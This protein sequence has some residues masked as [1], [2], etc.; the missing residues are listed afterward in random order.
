L[1]LVNG[2]RLGVGGEA[3]DINS[4]PAPL[5][6]RV[7]VLTG[8]AST[9]YGSDA[10]AGVVNFIMDTDFTGVRGGVQ[11]S[12]YQHDNNNLR[13]QEL[14][15]AAGYD[16]P[17]GVTWDGDALNVYVALGG[18]F[19]DGRGHASA[20][21]DY[22][23]IEDLTKADRDYLNCALSDGDDG[24]YCGGSTSSPRGTF[25]AFN[26]DWTFNGYYT[27]DWVEDGG[28]GHSFRMWDE[29]YYNYGPYNYIQRPDEK[30]NAGAF[31]HYTIND[32]F[33]PYAEIMFMDDYSDAQIAP[34]ANF[35]VTDRINCDNPM[36]S[37]QQRDVICTQAGY[38]PDDYAT[39]Y[40]RRRNSE[41]GP[42]TGTMGNFNYR[43][44]GGLR[45]DIN[46]FWSYDLYGLHAE[47][48]FQGS[49]L[50]DL[51]VQRLANALDVIEDPETGEW[52]CRSGSEDG[53][54]PWNIFQEGA[55]TQEA[56]DYI[57]TVA[58]AS[59]T[60]RTRV[61]NLTFKGDLEGHGLKI[62]SAIEGLQVAIG[63]EYRSELL[64]EVYDEVFLTGA[65]GFMGSAEAIDA[66]YGVKEFFVEALVPI[67][68]NTRGSRDLSLE[69]GYRYSD[70]NTSGGFNTYKGLLNWA[71]TDSW[72]LRGG[73]NRAVRAP[74]I[75]ELFRPQNASIG[76]GDICENDLETGV[77]EGT[78]EQCLRT[79][80][81]E[82]Q[83]GNI[84]AA[85]LGY[86]NTLWGGNPALEPEVADTITAG[87]VWT[88]RSIPGLSVTA[89]YYDIEVTE[90]IDWRWSEFIIHFC[91][92]TGGPGLCSRIHRDEVGSLWLSRDAYVDETYMNIGLYRTKGIDL[93]VDYLI[94]LGN[95]GYLTTDLIGTYLLSQRQAD[96][97]YDY[98]CVGYFAGLC[99]QFNQVWRHRLRAT[100]EAKFNL[101]L[102][103]TWRRVG[104]AENAAASPDPDLGD[105][106]ELERARIN[107][108]EAVRA[109]DWFDFAASYT[110]R[111]GIQ[112]T[113][114][115]NNILDQEPPFMPGLQDV[116]GTWF[117]L[118]GNY[119]PLGRHIFA[120][121][122]FNF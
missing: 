80:V 35:G 113:L 25:V 76:G 14:N 52:V 51:S 43:L 79:G 31:V 53:C 6:K 47:I 119:D 55:V 93:N 77:P 23:N 103:L 24:P 117:N 36:L 121:V 65:G 86:I 33:E 41:G 81:T 7:D 87:V 95:A 22:R 74:N 26:A 50:N 92:E 9:V 122:Q 100:W 75:F 10:V 4:I 72:R 29:D 30:W 98:D 109:Y 40:I 19:A 58:L 28:D 101:N 37:D 16:Y 70:Y 54:V 64:Q 49:W 78:L 105:P 45:G 85:P 2:R 3:A 32:H 84:P 56:V 90:A 97:S 106:D 112:L 17:T 44:V 83:Y 107:G 94:G 42:R 114:G 11:Y 67:L 111:N 68:Q 89:D 69:L 104:P 120:S 5:V 118:Y 60:A 15:E 71:I 27:L 18:A 13:A 110:W 34:S 57:S 39:V 115:V 62:P 99:D 73:Y 8:G 46:D 12:V 59:G 88:P 116:S 21:I 66:S 82:E 38:G 20:Y 91:A 61:L 63:A 48:N 108:T 1:V 96:P 102:S